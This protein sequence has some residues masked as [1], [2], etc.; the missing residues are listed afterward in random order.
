MSVTAAPVEF[1]PFSDDFF[2]D[3]TE[4][5]RRL[6]DEAPISFN[7]QYGFYALARFAD[8]L[9]AHRDWE[10]FSSAHGIELF[11]FSMD[12]EEI[13]S[14]RSIIMMDPPEH[15]RFRAL[16]S[17]VFTP[18]AVAALEPMIRDVICG[19]LDPF[20]DASALDAVADFAAPFPVEVIARMLGVPEGERQQIRHWLDASLHREAGQIAPSPENEQAVLESA[21][22]FHELTVEKRKNPGDDMLSRLT[23]VTVDRGDGTETGLDDAEITGFVTLL[24]GAGAETVTKLVGNAVMLFWQHPDQ[25]QKI[26]DDRDKIPRAVDEILRYHPPSQYQGRYCVEER[27]LESGT[28]PAGY[29]VL[30]LTGAA[31]RDPRAFERADE[32]DIERQPGITI[33]FGHGAHSC[34]GAAL[35]RMESRIAIEELA[36]RWQRLDVDEA[37]LRRVQ[38]ANVAGYANVPVTTAR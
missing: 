5:Y 36:T 34:L 29:P 4:I 8:V 26:L 1:D 33:G 24:G 10:G 12:P 16:V 14:F 13:A 11:T 21:V 30:L 20:N 38:M 17:R 27:E 15:D 2:N 35:A 22:Y 28:V 7:E 37:G 6:R 25:W 31:T 32:F 18:R 9:A 23:Q 19:F 3:P